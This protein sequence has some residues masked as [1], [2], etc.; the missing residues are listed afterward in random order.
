MLKIFKPTL[1]QKKALPIILDGRD[2]VINSK[3]GSGK[4]LCYL[5]PIINKLSVHSKTV[6]SRALII[7]PTK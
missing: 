6:G 3:T 7:T 5:L 2:T 1:I 4:T